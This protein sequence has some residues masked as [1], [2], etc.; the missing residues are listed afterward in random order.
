MTLQN[1]FE[2]LA[3]E[4]KQDD[5]ITAL[6]DVLT[7]LNDKFEAGEEVALDATTLAALESITA[8]VSG[9][10]DVGNFPAI[11]TV[12]GEV[13]LDAATLSALETI[14]AVVSGS[15]ALDAG[16]LSAL[17]N[18]TAVISG[19][20]AVTGPLT[21]TQLRATPVPVSGTV[22]VANPTTNPE[23]GLAKDGTDISSPTAMPAGGVGI[24]GWLSAIW[25]KL[26]G[27][28][29]ISGAVTTG[30]LTD[31]QL[32]A[33]AV[34]VSGTVTA[35]TGGLT[36]TQLRATAVPVSGTVTASG[37]LTD[38]QLRATPPSVKQSTAAT[39]TLATVAAS[40]TS[41]TLQASNSSRRGLFIVNDSAT[42][43]LYVAFAASATTSAYTVK[44]SAGSYYEVPEPLYTGVVSG[45]WDVAS[46]NARMTELT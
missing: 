23:T 37:P 8:T 24:R 9:T 12:D 7:E 32:R 38:T 22:T 13:S 26:N 18:I 16:T 4:S 3:V 28:I 43:T 42:A 45:I 46:G 31:T 34:P 40:A 14:N 29:T 25:T 11:Q 30:G 17:E 39:A 41:V 15:V 19:S 5:I 1:A 35:T 36:D 27:T 6:A 21:D 33:T 20:V 10:V 2:N 44:L